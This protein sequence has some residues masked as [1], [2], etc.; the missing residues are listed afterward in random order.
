M[1]IL[2]ADDHPLVLDG[3]KSAIERKFK[4]AALYT[5]LRATELYDH[6]KNQEI[7]ILFQ[8]IKFGE[9]HAR[10][11]L[12]DLKLNYP[13]LKIIMLTSLADTSSIQQFLQRADGYIIKSESIDIIFEAIEAVQ[14]GE[15]Y[16]S[17]EVKR[18]LAQLHPTSEIILTRREQD[19]LALILK[20]KSIKEI[21][22][23][24]G[25]S[26]KTV[27]MHRGNLFA[28]LEVKN[29]SGLV[30]KAIA[31]NLIEE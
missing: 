21:A 1:N 10:D 25:I 23:D 24:L 18:K 9:T 8:D 15:R 3:L 19:V 22:Q 13:K 27:E 26:E 31:L 30:Q 2:L 14:L 6:L 16:L 5:A 20:A 12:K 11:I 29:V 4:D 28:K 7:D 17:P